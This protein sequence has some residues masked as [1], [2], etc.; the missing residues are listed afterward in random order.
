MRDWMLPLIFSVVI[1]VIQVVF[2]PI[3]TVFSAV[4]SFI[5]SFVLVLSIM[6]RPDTTYVYAFVLGLI[7]DLLTHTP[8]G[9]T[10]LLLLIAVF[11]LSRVF[12]VLDDTSLAMPL[13]ALAATLL[14]FELLFAIILL[15]LGYQGSIFEIFAQRVIPATI[16]NSL[17][18]LLMK[19]GRFLPRVDS[20]KGRGNTCF[21]LFSLLLPLLLYWALSLQLCSVCAPILLTRGLPTVCEYAR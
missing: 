20:A 12:E 18:E 5:V 15:V 21:P 3:L 8:V 10:P 9:L 16:L 2:A 7:A 6:R 17:I 14:V 4:P 11:C 13:I 19:R 1:V